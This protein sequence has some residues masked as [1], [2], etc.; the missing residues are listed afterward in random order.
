VELI[1]ADA[2]RGDVIAEVRHRCA[3]IESMLQGEL[4]D[5]VAKLDA[6]LESF[7]LCQL[8]ARHAQYY[9]LVIAIRNLENP[10]ESLLLEVYFEI[11]EPLVFP[12]SLL[13]EQA[14]AAGILVEEFDSWFVELP[15]L[16]ELVKEVSGHTLDE[17]IAQ[18][19]TVTQWMV[20]SIRKLVEARHPTKK[21]T[22]QEHEEDEAYDWV[23]LYRQQQYP[24]AVD[25]IT[26]R[27]RDNPRRPLAARLYNDRGY[28]RYGIPDEA[29]N[30]KR[31]LEMAVAF[32]HRALSLTLLNLSVLAIDNQD[33]TRAIEKIED[34]LLITHGRENMRAAYL[35]LRLLP[36]HLMLATREKW[37]Q[38]PANV[39]EAAYVNLVYASAQQS[40]Y[41]VAKE[42][43]E[44]SLELM[45]TSV[46]L[47]HAFARLHL[48]K[49]RADLADAL[50]L[51]MAAM[52]I[53]D[54]RL[55]HE[56]RSY[57][58]FRRPRRRP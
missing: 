3:V 37:E 54:T 11:G 13:T 45:P 41:D 1:E 51:E 21:E 6:L 49:Q 57:L 16:D 7:R 18:S 42:V 14:E 27:L 33:Y 55:M 25:A 43:L 8:I 36:S 9:L 2:G 38:H 19:G 53:A 23:D 52:P 30:A 50:Y 28:I 22:Q 32:H 5:P 40:G 20:R 29:E 47:R 39:L 10:R 44:E 12:L 24:A 56:I 46:H 4:T 34:A 48:W 26:T 35:R 58:K 15:T 31:D 17:L